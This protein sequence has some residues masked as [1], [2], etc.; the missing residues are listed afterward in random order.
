M[1]LVYAT[2][3]MRVF[4]RTMDWFIHSVL[5]FLLGQYSQFVD[6]IGRFLGQKN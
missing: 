2:A 3:W 4:L 6:K 1:P 5:F